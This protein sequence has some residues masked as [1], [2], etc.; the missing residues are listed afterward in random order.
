MLLGAIS[1][2]FPGQ[3]ASFAYVATIIVFGSAMLVKEGW[4]H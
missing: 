2:R 1:T 4:A 3:E